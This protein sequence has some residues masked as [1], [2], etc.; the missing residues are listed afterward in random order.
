M[1]GERSGPFARSGTA[2]RAR[3]AMHQ[4]IRTI[5]HSAE[6]GSALPRAVRVMRLPGYRTPRW[7]LSGI[8]D[9]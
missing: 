3:R 8:A 6:H 5:R 2:Q 9:P 7:P 1:I 4:A